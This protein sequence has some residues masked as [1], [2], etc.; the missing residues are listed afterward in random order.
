[1]VSALVVLPPAEA[2]KLAA[3]IDSEVMRT[4][5]TDVDVD[6]D[7]DLSA[8]PT[9]DE[10]MNTE[11]GQDAPAGTSQPPSVTEPPSS[12]APPAPPTPEERSAW[13]I[14]AQQRADA[15]VA[16]LTNGG[17]NILTE[18]IFHVRGDGCTLDDGTPVPDHAVARLLPTALI[19]MLIHD[20]ERRPINASRRQR[21][22][23]T[24]QKRVVRERDQR[25]IDC[26]TTDL[27]QYDHEPD[28]DITRHTIIEELRCRCSRCHRTRHQTRPTSLPVVR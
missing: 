11:C 7:V 1:M 8:D 27:I 19:R 10:Q 26:G 18:V 4:R 3:A 17:A 22:P 9:R 20:A 12:S 13:P 16:L 14:L 28:Y 5:T 2:G 24:R 21:I 25:C 6:L 15:L 23:T